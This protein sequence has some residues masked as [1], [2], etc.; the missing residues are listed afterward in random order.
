MRRIL[1]YV[2]AIHFIDSCVFAVARIPSRNAY[3]QSVPSSVGGLTSS[4]SAKVP[5][6]IELDKFSISPWSSGLPASDLSNT[7][8]QGTSAQTPVRL[9][10]PE[11]C[12]ASVSAYTTTVIPTPGPFGIYTITTTK[13]ETIPLATT[14]TTATTTKTITTDGFD[15][16]GQRKTTTIFNTTTLFNNSTTTQKNVEYITVVATPSK[17]YI[18]VVSTPNKEF[19]T[20]TSTPSKEYVTV[21]TTRSKEYVTVTST[22]SKEY[23][24]VTSIPSKEYVTITVSPQISTATTT[25]TTTKTL[26]CLWDNFFG[27]DTTV[28]G[29]I[30]SKLCSSKT[31]TDTF[32][33]TVTINNA[34]TK[35]ETITATVTSWQSLI[36]TATVTTSVNFPLFLPTQTPKPTVSMPDATNILGIILKIIQSLQGD[37]P[38]FNPVIELIKSAIQQAI[39]QNDEKN[40]QAVFSFVIDL[41]QKNGNQNSKPFSF[42]RKKLIMKNDFEANVAEWLT[43]QLKTIVM[44]PKMTNPE[45]HN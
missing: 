41:I 44:E 18:T 29:S 8:I 23:V 25:A 30:A 6:S 11:I 28:P 43:N 10:M 16:F 5:S 12:T 2:D 7:I 45:I 21:T 4:V 40:I 24:T 33:K 15:F 1:Q 19:I 3:I 17:E 13:T 22:P 27:P 26:E 37:T 31:A 34:I 14:T 32:T 9:V 36:S 42:T 20:V 38:Q 39:K 35:L